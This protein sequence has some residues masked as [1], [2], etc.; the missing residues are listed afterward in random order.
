M[1]TQTTRTVVT[2]RRVQ[3]G[4]PVSTTGTYLRTRTG[5]SNP[6]YKQQIASAQ[7]A[8]TYFSALEQTVDYNIPSDRV[9]G[10]RV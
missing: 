7:D 3:N 10:H 5:D 8:T 4:T 6:K 9:I 1:A 2:L